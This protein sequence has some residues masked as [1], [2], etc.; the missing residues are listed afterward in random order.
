MCWD[1]IH[2]HAQSAHCT[3]ACPGLHVRDT[4]AVHIPH[5]P[6]LT[7]NIIHQTC[8]KKILLFDIS[9][10]PTPKTPSHKVP[11][12]NSACQFCSMQI[13]PQSA[14]MQYRL[15]MDGLCLQAGLAYLAV[16]QKALPGRAALSVPSSLFCSLIFCWWHS[17]VKMKKTVCVDQAQQT[18][19][20]CFC[21]LWGAASF[22]SI[23]RLY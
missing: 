7:N 22:C 1:G 9:F 10:Y 19:G 14:N 23:F 2:T 11:S 20:Y 18:R 13:A 16:L 4:L 15:A 6:P 5:P 17:D 3:I 12:K 8:K 21:G